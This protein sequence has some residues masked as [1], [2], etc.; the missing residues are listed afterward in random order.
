MHGIDAVHLVDWV[1]HM[2]LRIRRE[3]FLQRGAR[4]CGC[5][6]CCGVAGQKLQ[7]LPNQL[8]S[9]SKMLHP[10]I[11]ANL[12]SANKAS[13]SLHLWGKYWAFAL[14]Y[15]HQ[16][17]RMHKIELALGVSEYLFTICLAPY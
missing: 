2:A 15:R 7:V 12:C 6:M 17:I 4:I 3:K 9:V 10:L 16:C 11:I 14:I 13:G 1:K 5:W 8:F